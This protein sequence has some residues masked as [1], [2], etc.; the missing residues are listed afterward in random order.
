[1]RPPRAVPPG[2]R[3]MIQRGDHMQPKYD[4]TYQLG[5]TTV[6]IVAPPP[7]TEEEKVEILAE[8]HRLA[9]EAWNSL[10]VKERQRINAEIEAQEVVE[11]HAAGRASKKR[12]LAGNKSTDKR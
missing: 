9:W 2:K 6:H 3:H 12:R 8:F 5:K 10:P 1:M 4:A 7:M 11:Q